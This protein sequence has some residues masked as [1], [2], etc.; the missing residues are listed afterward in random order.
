LL[1]SLEIKKLFEKRLLVSFFFGP[2]SLCGVVSDQNKN[3][4]SRKNSKNGC[5][6]L[7][8][9]RKFSKTVAYF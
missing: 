7:S 4:K 2:L 6:F 8:T 5:S 3:V 1:I 9:I